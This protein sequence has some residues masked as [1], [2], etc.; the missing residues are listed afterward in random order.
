MKFRLAVQVAMLLVPVCGMAATVE[1]QHPDVTI[2][3]VD[4]SLDSVLT[5]LGEEMQLNV[6]T[7]LGINPI[8]NCDIQNQPIKQAFKNLL[9]DLSYSLV[10]ADDGERLTGLV[11]FTGDGE[12]GGT[13]V[14]ERQSSGV[15]SP[16]LVS[17][18]SNG[19]GSQSAGAPPRQFEDDPRMAEHEAEMAAQRQEHD[20]R[21]AEER[22]AGE[23][24]MAQVRR[25]QEILHKA[26][27]T[28]ERARIEAR[29]E[30]NIEAFRATLVQ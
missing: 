14:S 3:A 27:I 17:E 23:L 25:E 5:T 9:G 12:P 15:T 11:I 21:M 6:T 10:W 16:Q 8:I 7:P 19:G 18:S 24:E 22:E 13:V 29:T 30:A 2:V 4:E 1:Y 26:K 20:A 28:E